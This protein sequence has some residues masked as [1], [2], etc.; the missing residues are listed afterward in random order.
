M[1]VASLLGPLFAVHR[2]VKGRCSCR[3]GGR[4]P[5]PGKH[6][7]SPHG[8]TDAI[9]AD[10][11]QVEQWLARGR[12]IGLHT[13]SVFVLDKDIRSGGDASLE[14]LEARFGKLPETP[15]DLTGNGDH[16]FFELPEGLKWRD[17]IA[18]GLDVRAGAGRYVIVPP[19]IHYSGRSYQWDDSPE[20][21][22][23]APLPLWLLQRAVRIERPIGEATGKAAESLLGRAF[24]IAGHVTKTI[25]DTRIAVKCPWSDEHTHG[26]GSISSTVIFA[27]TTTRPHGAFHCSHAHCAGRTDTA[28]LAALAEEAVDQ[29]VAELNEPAW[30]IADREAERAAIQWEA[31]GC[32][33]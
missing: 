20:H 10:E 14:A 22:K 18:A 8:C 21:V 32:A 23:L 12:N 26:D 3:L 17:N 4:C 11:R 15:R 31:A 28:A 2:A 29:A 6:P 1:I 27:P 5:E 7:D 24:R 30:L 9:E 33:A 25:D 16:T 19:S 13:V